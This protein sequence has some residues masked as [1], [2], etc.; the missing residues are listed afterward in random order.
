MQINISR[1]PQEISGNN[2][3]VSATVTV[4]DTDGSTVGT[5]EV[6]YR[7][8]LT[9][10][11]WP[12]KAVDSLASQATGFAASLE[13]LMVVKQIKS[14]YLSPDAALTLDG[15][16]DVLM[17]QVSRQANGILRGTPV[18]AAVFPTMSA[19]ELNHS[20]QLKEF[21]IR[22]EGAHRMEEIA[23][24]Y[25]PQ[26][27]DT[28]ASQ[29]TEAQEYTANPDTAETPTLSAIA[30][31]RNITVAELVPLVIA[32]ADI[33]RQKA[34]EVL[35]TQQRLIGQIWAATTAEELGAVTW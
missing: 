18:S 10:S 1:H 24:P 14:A 33:F 29:L 4:L 16:I 25:L 17:T 22:A 28:W 20:K 30:A 23:M 13:H 2:I 35:G 15:S 9:D 12:V 19:D 5:T 3:T 11:G 21:A 27:R 31:G 6:S 26:E 34:G 7:G 8:L 32:N